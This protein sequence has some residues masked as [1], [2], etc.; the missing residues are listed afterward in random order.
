[1]KPR[2]FPQSYLWLAYLCLVF[3]LIAGCQTR[4][5]QPASA[6]P[7]SGLTSDETTTL[8]SLERVSDYPLYTMHYMG[9]YQQYLSYRDTQETSELWSCTLFAALGDTGQMLYGRNFDW[10][11]SPALLLFTNPADGYA[12]VSMVDIAYLGFDKKSGN[13]ADLPLTERCDLLRAP[14]LPFDG[15]NEHG[16]V[17]GMAAVPESKLPHDAQKQTIGSLGVMREVLDHARNTQEAVGILD[18]YNIDFS[19]GPYLHYL[20]ADATGKSVLVEFFDGKLVTLPNAN[21]W[22]LATN[23]LRVNAQ[24]DGG[25]SRYAHARQQLTDNGGVLA[26]P[27]AMQLLEE[28]SQ[29]GD[30]PTQWSILYGISTGKVEVVMGR[31]YGDAYTFILP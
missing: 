14:A 24:G 8:N 29:A 9:G 12:S 18:S 23:H 13:L 27:K 15:M 22:H 6:T 21:P 10:Q 31:N 28:V 19:D 1:M 5:T 2:I 17:I 4:Q 26:F 16:L 20:I 7:T 3:L 11:Y 25:C 30:Y